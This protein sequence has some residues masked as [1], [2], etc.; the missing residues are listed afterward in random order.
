MA[1]SDE[2]KEKDATKVHLAALKRGKAPACPKRPWFILHSQPEC[3][4]PSCRLH[5]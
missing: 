3:P 5:L 2:V 1:P 4:A